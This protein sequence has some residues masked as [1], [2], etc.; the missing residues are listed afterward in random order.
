MVSAIAKKL[1]LT[2]LA[3]RPQPPLASRDEKVGGNSS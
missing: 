1:R 3:Q 2:N